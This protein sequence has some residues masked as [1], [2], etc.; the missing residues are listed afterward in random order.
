MELDDDLSIEENDV[1]VSGDEHMSE[2]GSTPETWMTMHRHRN[3]SRPR[4]ADKE[5]HVTEFNG[6]T[7]RIV[8]RY[9][10]GHGNAFQTLTIRTLQN[11]SLSESETYA[12]TKQLPRRGVLRTSSYDFTTDNT[13]RVEERVDGTSAVATR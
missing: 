1:Q 12:S 9:V 6:T 10:L 11:R 8:S 5:A 4:L 7:N 2:G 13:F 3:V